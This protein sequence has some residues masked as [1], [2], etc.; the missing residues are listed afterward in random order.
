MSIT[1]E[2]LKAILADQQSQFMKLLQNIQIGNAPPQQNPSQSNDM[3]LF[4]K[5]SAQISEFVYSP[6][7]NRTFEEWYERFGP[8]VEQEGKPMSEQSKVRLI[9]SKL[10]SD[11]YRRYT[12]SIQPKT[13][14]KVG[15]LDT[16]S[17]LRTIFPETKSIFIK[18]YECFRLKCEVNQDVLAFGSTVNTMAE[19]SKLDLTKDQIKSL[20]F[21]TGLGEH[22]AELRYRCIKLLDGNANYEQLLADCKEVIAL[23]QSSAALSGRHDFNSIQIR[24][25]K[26]QHHPKNK[27]PTRTC[28]LSQPSQHNTHTVNQSAVKHSSRSM[29]PEPC[30]RC[31]GDHWNS[32][33]PYPKS[34][35]CHK[36][37]RLGH[38]STICRTKDK[39]QTNFGEPTNIVECLNVT[40]ARFEKESNII[41]PV[42]CPTCTGGSIAH[43]SKVQYH[44]KHGAN[45]VVFKIG[46]QFIHQSDHQQDTSKKHHQSITECNHKN[47]LIR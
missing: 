8:F 23:R 1:S 33:C 39:Q 38:I 27:S 37:G 10:G 26:I 47:G 6:D 40:P 3:D 24:P 21:I 29:P 2:Q 32:D 7:D 30:H 36:C 14:E 46:D 11:E 35:K 16:I 31:G 15:L 5:L 18:R 22:N 43:K 12:E 20:I 45:R 42:K 9:V 13:P 4:C 19:K 28:S 34:V 17:K 25:S 44:R 41:V